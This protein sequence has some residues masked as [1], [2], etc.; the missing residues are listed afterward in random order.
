M[1]T[2][3]VF[4]LLVIHDSQNIPSPVW[5]IQNIQTNLVSV[6]FSRGSTAIAF[7]MKAIDKIMFRMAIS[8][9]YERQDVK[10]EELLY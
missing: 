2:V 4:M 8:E 10:F 3:T 6:I 7:E 1:A 5:K 9:W